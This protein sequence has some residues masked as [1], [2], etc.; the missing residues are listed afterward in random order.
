MTHRHHSL[1]TLLLGLLLISPVAQAADEA[2][3]ARG[4]EIRFITRVT[5]TSL[6]ARFGGEGVHRIDWQIHNAKGKEVATGSVAPSNNTPRI[7]YTTLEPGKYQLW[8]RGQ[9][10]DKVSSLDFEVTEDPVLNMGVIEKTAGGQRFRMINGKYVRTEILP[11]GLVKLIYP[12]TLPSFNGKNT[13]RAWVFNS[14]MIPLPPDELKALSTTGLKL[15]AGNH[16]F[17][18]YYFNA[19]RAKTVAEL[20]AQWWDL[21]GDQQGCQDNAT[22]AEYALLEIEDIAPRDSTEIKPPDDIHAVT[23]YPQYQQTRNG[24]DL[25]EGKKFG[26]TKRVDG[27][28]AAQLVEQGTYLQAAY[29]DVNN[30]NIPYNRTWVTLRAYAKG[31][32]NHPYEGTIKAGETVTVDKDG[33]NCEPGD[34]ISL[35]KGYSAGLPAG[36]EITYSIPEKGVFRF[37]IKNSSGEDK[38]F[39]GGTLDVKYFGSVESEA[40]KLY[41]FGARKGCIVA[42][43]ICE[44]GIPYDYV[45]PIYR[46]IYELQQ[47]HDGVTDP[48]ETDIVSDYFSHL[49]G[50]GTEMHGSADDK[51]KLLSSREMARKN[52]V[53]GHDSN[54]YSNRAYEYRHRIVGGYLDS[55]ARLLDGVRIYGHI[56]NLERQY[57]AMPDR[58]V[59]TFGWTAF[60]GVSSQV[61]RHATWQRLPFEGGDLLRVSRMEGS[62]EQLKYETFFSLL[63]GDYYVSWNDNGMFGT[64]INRFGLAHIGGGADW[65]NRWAPRGGEEVQYDPNDSTHPQS[66]PGEGAG[67]SDGAAPGHNGGFVGAWLLCQ[68]KNRIDRTLRYPSFSYTMGD[69][70]YT[71]YFN[72]NDPVKGEK[73]DASISRFGNGNA[74]QC[75]IVNQ[76]EHRKPIVIYGEGSGGKCLIVINPYAGLTETTTYTLLD[77]PKKRSIRHRGPYLGVYRL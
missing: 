10:S 35:H 23:W 62:F 58:R 7:T 57:I 29:A 48:N 17:Y 26:V 47:E 43:E 22:G 76:E 24:L 28:P 34:I 38:P 51:R 75:N 72:G 46:R 49:Y 33:V 31:Q 64:N 11:S 60:E 18:V 36:V 59:A 1:P 52:G 13:T 27:I 45:E 50:Y 4:P 41:D 71:G 70:T 21:A 39:A 6:F 53:D 37:E 54:Y 44:N 8:F 68:I 56:G 5:Q 20:R 69:K 65:K 14:Y 67:W 74:G 66:Q 32:I 16:S 61:E 25:P 30:N 42:S 55:I 9:A 77:G 40:R 2:P 15:R 19:A 3:P 63:I 12:E 73:G